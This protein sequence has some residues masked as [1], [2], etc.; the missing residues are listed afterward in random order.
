GQK[1]DL[2]HNII[3]TLKI[4]VQNR[5][6]DVLPEVINQFMTLYHN[7]H[8]IAEIDVTSVVPLTKEQDSLLTH[9]LATIFSKDV[10]INY[11]TNP[12][13]I[14]GLV[15]KYGTHFIDASVRSKLN[16]LEKFMKGKQ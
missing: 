7:A 3:N 4:L 9:K 15:I 5:K 8:N 10:I 16:A 2:P 14:G 13:I 6:I 12:Q 1:F 11:S